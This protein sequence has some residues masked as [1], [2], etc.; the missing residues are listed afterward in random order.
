MCINEEATDRAQQGEA[1]HAAAAEA[2][3]LPDR[4]LSEKP[5]PAALP[6]TVS[7]AVATP[8]LAN[9]QAAGT[10]EHRTLASS[11]AVDDQVLGAPGKGLHPC[12]VPRL[13]HHLPTPTQLQSVPETSAVWDG[14]AWMLASSA[15]LSSFVM[16]APGLDMLAN[17]CHAEVLLLPGGA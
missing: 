12:L 8:R 10:R 7:T 15:A 13:H 1:C 6:S 3:H 4:G 17:A 9:L 11:P 5:A 14:L 16:H 2:W